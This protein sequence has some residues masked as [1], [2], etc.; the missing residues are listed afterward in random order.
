MSIQGAVNDFRVSAVLLCASFAALTGCKSNS[1]TQ[2][3]NASPSTANAPAPAPV[4][5]AT[6]GTLTG[7]IDLK[8]TP[9][10]RVKIDMSM[11]PACAFAGDN[12]TEQYIATGGHLANVFVYI[13][14]GLPASSAPAGTAPVRIDQKGCRFIP[15]VAGVQQ[16]GPVEF[17]NS[18]PTMHNVHT[19]A[20]VVGNTNVDVS[21]GP[22]G[23]P[24]TRRFNAPETML[25]IRCN[26]HPWMQAFLNVA[27]NPYFAVTGPDGSFTIPNLPPG[28]YTLAA[29]HEKLGEQDTQI[30]IAPHATVRTSLTFSMQ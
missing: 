13:K 28:T 11:D 25:P 16:G 26:N 1:A 20:T 27:P 10:A 29:V 21:Q 12:L 18:D 17:T 9:P 8:G 19:M 4:D 3:T 5:P 6:A 2:P 23:E 30:T 15:H 24:Q 22:N 14:S 7:T